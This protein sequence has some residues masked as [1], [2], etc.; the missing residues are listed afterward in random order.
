M[1]TTICCPVSPCL[2]QRTATKHLPIGPGDEMFGPVVTRTLHSIQSVSKEMS[3]HPA[4]LR[5]LLEGVGWIDEEAAGLTAERVLFDA[6]TLEAFVD[7]M[8]DAINWTDARTYLNASRSAWNILSHGGFI[9][10]AVASVEGKS[11]ISP[12]YHKAEL[13]DFLDRLRACA[14]AENDPGAGRVSMLEAVKKVNCKYGEVVQLLL[15]RKLDNASI[16]PEG[17]GLEAILVDIQEV[18]EQTALKAHG[19]LSLTEA[20][21]RLAVRDAVLFALIDHGYLASEIGIN[22]TNRCPQR[23]VRPEEIERFE[24]EYVSLFNYA[25]QVGIHFMKAKTHLDAAGVS[26]A[27]TKDLVKATFYRWADIR[28]AIPKF[29]EM[30]V[31]FA[32]A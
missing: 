3:F 22:P 5:K 20:E 2:P 19:G 31:P 16:D 24:S 15:D 23:I 7:K 9:P 6:A 17:N 10:P 1:A 8:R 25:K 27:L 30:G 18:R 14:R 12:F 21:A 32:F 4:T 29:A 11:G 28:A 13:D 26:P